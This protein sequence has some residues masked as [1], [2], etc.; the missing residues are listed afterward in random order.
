M[1]QQK[2][3]TFILTE[4]QKVNSLSLKDMMNLTGAS[5]DTIRRDIIK[6]ADQNLVTR[7]YGGISLP[8]S[9]SKLDGYLE[10]STDL[11]TIKKR[12]TKKAVS[13]IE[14][15][16]V[17]Y[18]D[19]ST[20]ISLLPQFLPKNQDFFSVT[21][22][23]DIADQLLK[24]SDSKTTILGGVLD[25]EKRF[26]T[27]GQSILDI[28]KYHFDMAFLSCAGITKE[29]IYYAHEE[30]IPLKEI[31]REQSKKLVVICDHTKINT[32][33]NFLLYP[34]DRIDYLVTDKKLPEIISQQIDPEKII[35]SKEIS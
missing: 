12:L 9:F 3:L 7:N 30:D 20:T 34:F 27:G 8:N 29:G 19:V 5:R 32:S 31:I 28:S 11:V 14:N 33:H 35:Y 21:N 10:R 2:R 26:S 23:I 24:N 15:E 13:L 6:L 25:R 1:N 16:K 17:L 18:F 4:L 22:S